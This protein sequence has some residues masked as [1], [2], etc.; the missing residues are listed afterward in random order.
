MSR[1]VL[2]PAALSP[3]MFSIV[4]GTGG[5]S[6]CSNL[7]GLR[8]LALALLALNAL[9]LAVAWLATVLRAAFGFRALIVDLTDLVRG[10]GFFFAPLATSIFGIQIAVLTEAGSL[11]GPL[12]IFSLALWVLLSCGFVVGATIREDKASLADAISP[13]WFLPGA[14]LIVTMGFGTHITPEATQFMLVGLYGGLLL[15]LFFNIVVMVA[16]LYRWLFLPLRA[17]QLLANN[18]INMGG[19]AIVVVAGLKLAALHAR[20][21]PVGAAP[22]TEIPLRPVIIFSWIVATWWLPILFAIGFWRH[23]LKRVPLRYE[24]SNW[25]LVFS[26]SVY[27][28]A[29][30]GLISEYHFVALMWVPP[31]FVVFAGVAWIL[32]MIGFVRSLSRG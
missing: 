11:V 22:W 15:G 9:L 23:A 29:T 28:L 31:A 7:L 13:T 27:A 12:W 2:S 4:L 26:P 25:A 20:S 17:E 18:W 16:L 8:G 14:A 3:A 32:L 1:R 24:P 6:L 21:V 30:A 10:P 19:F 5:V